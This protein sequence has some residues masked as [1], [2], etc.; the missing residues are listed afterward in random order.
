M[1]SAGTQDASDRHQPGSP[2]AAPGGVFRR[3]LAWVA[4]VFWIAYSGALLGWHALTLPPA[5]A[6]IVR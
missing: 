6:C 5:D 4:L 3:R 1:F 2:Q